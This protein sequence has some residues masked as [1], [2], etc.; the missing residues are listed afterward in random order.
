MAKQI[1]PNKFQGRIDNQVFYKSQDGFLVKGKGGASADR[2]AND[3]S[4]AR[5]RENYSEFSAASRA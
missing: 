1:G 5:T 2:I 4:F 3:P